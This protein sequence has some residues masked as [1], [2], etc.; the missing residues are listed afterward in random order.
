[1]FIEVS[2]GFKDKAHTRLID[3]KA[4]AHSKGEYKDCIIWETFL[5]LRRSQTD[6]SKPAFFLS[7]NKSDY[8]EPPYTR[9]FH[10]KLLSEVDKL[11][12]LYTMD[13]SAL[14]ARLCELKIYE[15]F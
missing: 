10:P 15:V 13:Y 3:K 11:N 2:Q 14:D 12:A 5:S 9:D 6:K 4:P 8:C 7:S 1:M